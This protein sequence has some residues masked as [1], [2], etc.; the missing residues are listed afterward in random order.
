MIWFFSRFPLLLLWDT[1]AVRWVTDII[2]IF[3]FLYE[4]SFRFSHVQFY[5]MSV[6]DMRCVRVP[7]LCV[8]S[9]IRV[10]QSSSSSFVSELFTATQIELR[11]HYLP[12]T[13]ELW[14][15]SNSCL[16]MYGERNKIGLGASMFRSFVRF[17]SHFVC[18]PIHIQIRILFQL[19]AN[20]AIRNEL[21]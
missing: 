5:S 19:F 2:L 18:L 11:D 1:L 13:C 20:V 10:F 21:L 14:L 8:R 17:S 16:Y 4:L 15:R 9:D 12:A 6:C 3:I 7:H